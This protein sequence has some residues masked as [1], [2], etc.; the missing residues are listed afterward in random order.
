MPSVLV[1]DTQATYAQTIA[2]LLAD[3]ADVNVVYLPGLAECGKYV[4]EGKAELL[5]IGPSVAED[6]ALVSVTSIRDAGSASCI[7]WFPLEVDQELLRSALRVGVDDVVSSS[8][9][10]ADIKGALLEALGK[11]ERRGGSRKD[12]PAQVPTGEVI[13]V[14]SMKGG[15]GK[16]V[17]ASNLAVALAGLGKSVALIDLDLQFGD[18]G[19]MLGIEPTQTIV[20]AVQ[21]GERLDAPMLRGFLIEH[22]SGVQVLLAPLSPEDAEIVTA[23]RV[24]RIIGLLTTMFDFVVI[25]TPPALDEAV[26]TALDR[27]TRIMMITMMDVA[28]VKNSRVSL[29]K[30]RQLGYNGSIVDIMLNRAD[31]KVYLKAEEVEQ[32]IGMPIKYR[33]PSD[34]QVPRSVN[35]G[36]PVVLDAPRSQPAKV[37]LET[38]KAIVSE[39]AEV[40]PDVA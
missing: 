3:V 40:S 28:S 8:A 18:V 22:A 17:V 5:V 39:H 21:S 25:D 36:M 29:Q 35:K 37:I 4:R 31:S 38:A 12:A 6:D 19:I 26:L 2:K 7:V 24:D 34:L 15:V 9:P 11:A 1:C 30:L 32:A 16:T 13:T 27:S 23:S 14:L 20:G 10:G 33:L